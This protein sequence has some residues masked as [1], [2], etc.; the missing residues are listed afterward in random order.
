MFNIPYA[1][2]ELPTRNELRRAPLLRQL[3]GVMQAPLRELDVEWDSVLP[4]CLPP[5]RPHAEAACHHSQLCP[6]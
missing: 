2:I 1:A 3:R 4:V 6:R 5:P